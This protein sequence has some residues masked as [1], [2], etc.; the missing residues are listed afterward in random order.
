[1]ER[2]WQSS[3]DPTESTQLR[4]LTFP[5]SEEDD[6]IVRVGWR[7]PRAKDRYHMTAMEV[8]MWMSHPLKYHVPLVRY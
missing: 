4:E 8:R 6:G 5:T 3:I 7:G 2:P 1:M